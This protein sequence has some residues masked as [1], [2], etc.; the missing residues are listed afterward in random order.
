[1]DWIAVKGPNAMSADMVPLLRALDLDGYEDIDNH[2]GDCVHDIIIAKVRRK[3]SN[4]KGLMGEKER[5]ER[6]NEKMEEDV[7]ERERQQQKEREK[8]REKWPP[9]YAAAMG[10]QA[11]QSLYT[12]K[13]AL[14][15][16]APKPRIS[17][18]KKI[19]IKPELKDYV[20]SLPSYSHNPSAYTSPMNHP[21]F[22]GCY[23]HYPYMGYRY[24]PQTPGLQIQP[25]DMNLPAPRAPAKEEAPK[26]KIVPPPTS[27]SSLSPSPLPTDKVSAVP[28]RPSLSS[29]YLPQAQIHTQ[30]QKKK[31]EPSTPAPP[32]IP[33]N[34]PPY[35][36]S[37]D[38]P[39][40]NR[41][42]ACMSKLHQAMAD[43]SLEI[44]RLPQD[45]ESAELETAA[46]DTGI[47]IDYLETFVIDYIVAFE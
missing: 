24:A 20:T 18:E 40:G 23:D 14:K 47:E 38:L 26:A 34:P 8:E 25:G 27:P 6:E 35:K 46:H 42:V 32:S 21:Y 16:Q 15:P 17:D 1:M 45:R 19:V 36:A 44:S 4:T 31:P 3:I 41:L 12:L 7:R 39:K 22:T 2:L 37:D 5:Q 43:L 30:K 33:S 13:P 9:Y 10:A 11:P 29:T 28:A